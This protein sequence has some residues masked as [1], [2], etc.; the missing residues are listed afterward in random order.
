[1][2]VRAANFVDIPAIVAIGADVHGRSIYGP[3]STYD[4][5]M[6]KQLCARSMQRH[7]QMNY[8][9]TFFLVSETDGEVRGF[10]IAILDQV[11]PCVEE[12]MVTDLLFAGAENMASRDAITMIR[13]ID[14][15]GQS[16][17]KVIEIYLAVNDAVIGG[18]WQRVGK[19]YEHLGLTL[20]GGV[21][22]RIIDR[23]LQEVANV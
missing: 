16:N 2:S 6:A 17:P 14:A 10:I 11:Y 23:T 20:C 5:E 7:G 13:Q 18:D 1:M 22:R 19:M 4:R 9:G 8:G 3:I 15:W 21:Y 12:L